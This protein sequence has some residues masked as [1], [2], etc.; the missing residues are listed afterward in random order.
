L[1]IMD[2]NAARASA[3]VNLTF[4]SLAVSL[5]TTMLKSKKNSTWCSLCAECFVHISE[6]T[7]TFALYIIN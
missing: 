1:G 3:L 4:Q 7:A 5:R 2:E 6:Q